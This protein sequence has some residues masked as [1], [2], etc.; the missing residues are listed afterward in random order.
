MKK[1]IQNIIPFAIRV[2]AYTA[3]IIMV[4]LV[5]LK[6]MSFIN[7][8]NIEEPAITISTYF[9]CMLI[10]VVLSLADLIF[11]IK[12]LSLV[13]KFFLNF[14]ASLAGVTVCL[15]IGN[16]ELKPNSLLL[17]IIFAFAYIL[18]KPLC[19][20]IEAKIN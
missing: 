19:I 16:Y 6:I 18:I 9:L 12:N 8:S 4:L 17:I 5:F 14:L 1:T 7:V 20:W 11:K 3:T 15:L 10:A 2:L 13:A